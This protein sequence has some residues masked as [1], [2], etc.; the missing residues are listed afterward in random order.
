MQE[1]G[2]EGHFEPRGYAYEVNHNWQAYKACN[3]QETECS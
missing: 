1:I 2:G 3:T